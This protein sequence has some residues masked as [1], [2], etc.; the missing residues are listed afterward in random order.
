MPDS[1]PE[2]PA[3]LIESQILLIRGQKVLLDADLARLYQVT[4]GNLNLAVRRNQER[5]PEDFMFQLSKEEFENLR[6]QF[7]RSS[8][9]GRRHPPYAFTEQGIAMLSSVLN[10]ARAIQV[11][12]AIMRTF[13]RLRQ[14]LATHEELA[15]R[16]EHLEWRQ[17]EQAGQIQTVFETIKQL[18]D[19]PAETDP[20]SVE[21][22]RRIGF[23]TAEDDHGTTE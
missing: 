17:Y 14:I 12:I 4:T 19:A 7:A 15:L 8:W 22:K 10:S 16:L 18:I 3:P 11:N 9:G 21:P 1:P 6:L 5:F 20:P 13:V 2:V 23:P